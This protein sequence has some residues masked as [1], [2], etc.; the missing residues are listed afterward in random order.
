MEV[1]V[2]IGLL[3]FES[4][5]LP[6]VVERKGLCSD[7]VETD[8]VPLLDDLAIDFEGRA[9]TATVVLGDH[10]VKDSKNEQL[11]GHSLDDVVE[12]D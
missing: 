11:E 1:G 8:S 5:L 4:K 7:F 12:D 3:P 9:L 6:Q 10:L 2:R